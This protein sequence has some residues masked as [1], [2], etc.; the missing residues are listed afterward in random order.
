MDFIK[1]WQLSTDL[2]KIFKK[3]EDLNLLTPYQISQDYNL[4]RYDSEVYI[5]KNTFRKI[6]D[7]IDFQ[8]MKMLDCAEEDFLD[9]RYLERESAENKLMDYFR[10]FDF[11]V[12]SSQLAYQILQYKQMSIS[13]SDRLSNSIY[14]FGK[15]YG[16]IECFS[17]PELEDDVIICGKRKDFIYN[18]YLDK[19]RYFE[20]DGLFKID[21]RYFMDSRINL[22]E[23]KKVYIIS[24]NKRKYMDFLRKNS[25][26]KFV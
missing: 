18:F 17:N 24:E 16:G 7:N 12:S 4:T 8:I 26:D 11:I 15:L 6:E 20:E 19:F 3:Y 22:E 1:S 10:N 5:V 14:N 23:F 21:C 9:V 25:I 13:V 2:T